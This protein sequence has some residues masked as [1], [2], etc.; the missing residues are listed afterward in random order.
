MSGKGILLLVLSAVYAWICWILYLLVAR[1]D[2]FVEWF[3]RRPYRSWGINLIIEDE[4]KLKRK[5]CLFG[6]LG[7]GLVMFHAV[8]VIGAILKGK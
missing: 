1:P 7:L 5:G 4:S 3:W 8:L 6:R 2:R